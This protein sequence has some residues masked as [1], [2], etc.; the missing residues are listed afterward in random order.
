MHVIALEVVARLTMNKVFR[1]LSR[2]VGVV[3]RYRVFRVSSYL[4]M[5]IRLLSHISI[6]EIHAL[7]QKCT[8]QCSLSL[9]A[10]HACASARDWTTAML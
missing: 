9:L 10:V 2:V 6:I 4:L 1:Q 3:C 8:T 5:V 7:G